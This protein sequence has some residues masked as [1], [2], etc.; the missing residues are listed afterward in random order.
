MSVLA[1]L[2]MAVVAACFL[3]FSASTLPA[4]SISGRVIL[5]STG[6]PASGT[7][8]VLISDSARVLAQ[9]HADAQGVFAIASEQPGS[10]RLGFFLGARDAMVSPPFAL[11]TG[12]YVEREFRV[13]AGVAALG[14][15][16]LEKDVTKTVLLRPKN[17]SPAYPDAF[18]RQA[19]RGIVRLL[20]VVNEKGD[21]EMSTVQ[22]I[23][24][25]NEAFVEPVLKALRKSHYWPAEKDG[26]RV[27]QL[28]Q[29]TVD[30]GCMSD[31][32]RG[33]INVRS[34]YPACTTP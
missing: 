15:I 8:V 31:P 16:A 9:T 5:D 30:F 14:D 21:P 6:T 3:L 33:E 20:F 10:F 29:L 18:A 24:A 27:A 2:R 28:T 11:D 32:S 7:V 23:G 34:L 19:V 1:L 12:A 17:P 26:R 22:V 25:S 13:P 4:Q